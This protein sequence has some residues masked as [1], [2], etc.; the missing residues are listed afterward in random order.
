MKINSWNNSKSCIAIACIFLR[1]S[2]QNISFNTLQLYLTLSYLLDQVR[3]KSHVQASVGANS[4]KSW[5]RTRKKQSPVLSPYWKK[6]K[7]FIFSKKPKT[8]RSYIHVKRSIHDNIWLAIWN[9]Y[10]LFCTNWKKNNS[11]RT[12]YLWFENKMKNKSWFF[13][14]E[15]RL[16]QTA[17]FK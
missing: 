8:S 16:L 13:Q 3:Q 6:F 10:I 9:V 4:F 14:V 7:S 11:V 5:H 17:S 2:F 15:S 12:T 1:S